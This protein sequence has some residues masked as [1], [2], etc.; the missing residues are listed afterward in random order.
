LDFRVNKITYRSILRH[1]FSKGELCCIETALFFLCERSTG[2]KER[3]ERVHKFAELLGQLSSGVLFQ[4]DDIEQLLRDYFQDHPA[5]QA[6]LDLLVTLPTDKR[7]LFFKTIGAFWESQDSV[8]RKA[9]DILV[10]APV[11]KCFS[12]HRARSEAL[13]AA[14]QSRRIREVHRSLLDSLAEDLGDSGLQ[15]ILEYCENLAPLG[16]KGSSSP[17]GRSRK[18]SFDNGDFE[19]YRQYSP[20]DDLRNFDW[21]LF[22]RTDRKFVKSY[23]TDAYDSTTLLVDLES[24]SALS[25]ESGLK[26]VLQFGRSLVERRESL[27]L[28]IWWRGTLLHHF[29]PEE[30]RCLLSGGQPESMKQIVLDM[31]SVDWLNRR[32][33]EDTPIAICP[34]R[35]TDSIFREQRDSRIVAFVAPY[36]DSERTRRQLNRLA[37]VCGRPGFEIYSEWLSTE[38]IELM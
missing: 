17:G 16:P 9:E 33:Y 30:A 31:L 2:E 1:A 20:G 15:S 29:R 36:N 19:E 12:E 37:R 27:S 35:L 21:K 34:F 32:Y 7:D 13:R 18:R 10:A 26:Q 14:F 11:S 5:V 24:F 25:R 22:G 6:A 4:G 38:V 8:S 28:Q 3:D 23:S